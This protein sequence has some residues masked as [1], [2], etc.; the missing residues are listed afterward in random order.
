LFST[1]GLLEFAFFVALKNPE[2]KKSDA[3]ELIYMTKEA[4][5]QIRDNRLRCALV[6]LIFV[7]SPHKKGGLGG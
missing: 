1:V 2:S 6:F 7:F 4:S 3:C 5:E